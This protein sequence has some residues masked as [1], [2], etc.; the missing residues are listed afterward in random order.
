MKRIL[1]FILALTMVLSLAACGG[2][3]D[4]NKGKTDVTMTAREILDTLKEKLGDSFECDVDGTEDSVSGYWGLDMSQVESWAAMSQSNS[5]LNPSTAVILQVKDGYAQDAAA[6]LQ[7]GY[8]QTLSY[9]RMYNMDLQKVLQARLFVN[10]NYV[11][12]LILGSEG[13]GGA[14]DEEQAKFAAGEAA[15]VDAAW[16]GIF[17][18]AENVIVIPEDDGSGSGGFFDMT[19][20]DIDPELPD[21]SNDPQNDSQKDSADS[22]K[23]DS[24]NQNSKKNT[25]DSGNSKKDDA[26]RDTE[27]KDTGKKDAAQDLSA[28]DVLASLKTSLGSSYTSDTAET[29]ARMS[30][31]YGLDMS[32]IESWAAESNASSSLNADCAVVLK[33]KDGY[34]QDAAALLQQSFDQVVSYARMYDMDLQRVLQGR[35]YINGNFVALIIEGAKPDS[36]ASDEEQAKFAAGEAGKVD[37]AWKALFGS[38]SN[39]IAIPAESASSNNGFDM[40]DGLEG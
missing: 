11:A 28:N 23:S 3:A 1:T 17:G 14:S 4:D 2:K 8:E 33:V 6:L 10:G 37:S 39:S 38:A 18:S 20:E 16:S 35:L 13:N 19:D 31:Y 36:S 27:K 26:K 22:A 24:S 15:K 40:S 5:A 25:A 7:T 34:A 9:S 29:E 21:G 12:L 32:R 30:G